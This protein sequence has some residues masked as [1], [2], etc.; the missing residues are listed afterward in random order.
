MKI[1]Y[2]K[3]VGSK[4]NKK[5]DALVL[6]FGYR[7]EMISFDGKLIAEILDITPRELS[8]VDV[9]DYEIG[10]IKE[11]V[12]LTPPAEGDGKKGVK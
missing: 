8:T 4:T 2:R 11:D 6:D 3:A 5:Y 1:I 12:Q 9:G 7:E 10:E